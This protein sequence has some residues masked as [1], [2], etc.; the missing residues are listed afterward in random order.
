MEIAEARDSSG[1]RT[2][3]CLGFGLGHALLSVVYKYNQSSDWSWPWWLRSTRLKNRASALE[4]N[5]LVG[6]VL[7]AMTSLILLPTSAMQDLPAELKHITKR[8]KRK[9]QRFPQ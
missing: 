6:F 7:A 1:R 9:Q 5:G 2:H 4:T 3:L 8:W